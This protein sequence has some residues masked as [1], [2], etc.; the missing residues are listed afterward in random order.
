[1]NEGRIG[2]SDPVDEVGRLKRKSGKNVLISG[3]ISV[4]QALVSADLVDE[5]RLVL[6]PVVLGK[7]RSLFPDDVDPMR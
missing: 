3:S 7:G 5:C 6:C 1:M 4:A 2:R